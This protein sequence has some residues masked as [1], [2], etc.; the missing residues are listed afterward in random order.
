MH[1]LADHGIPAG[2]VSSSVNVLPSQAPGNCSVAVCRLPRVD[3]EQVV[4]CKGGGLHT[5]P[6]LRAGADSGRM[7]GV[8][9]MGGAGILGRTRV[10]LFHEFLKAVC[11]ALPGHRCCRRVASH[12]G[13]SVFFLRPHCLPRK[14]DPGRG[15]AHGL[16]CP[17]LCPLCQLGSRRVGTGRHFPPRC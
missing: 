7:M 17:S 6:Q 14:A 2:P 3:R 9:R 12:G 16:V 11:G 5:L 15:E 13:C 1:L 10:L 4:F 8:S